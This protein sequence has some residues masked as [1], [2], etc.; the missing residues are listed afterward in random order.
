MPPA[1][2]AGG[3]LA[4]FVSWASGAPNTIVAAATAAVAEPLITRRT[5]GDEVI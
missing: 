1:V 2:S 5:V 4:K 3:G